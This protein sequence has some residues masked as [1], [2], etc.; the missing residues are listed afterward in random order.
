[1]SPNRPV[2]I[3]RPTRGTRSVLAVVVVLL[4][5][6]QGASTYAATVPDPG[7]IACSPRQDEAN[8]NELK[9][10]GGGNLKFVEMKILQD[11]VIVDDWQLCIREQKLQGRRTVDNIECFELGEGLFDLYLSGVRQG[12][13]VSD[14]P[15]GFSTYLVRDFN[16]NPTEAEILLVDENGRALDYLRYCSGSCSASQYW[17]VDTGC[18]VSVANVG[19]NTQVLARYPEDGT[20]DWMSNRETGGPSGP[21]QGGTN[22]A[23]AGAIDHFLITHDGTALT[24]QAETVT[25]TACTNADCSATFPGNVQ[26]TLAPNGWVGGNGQ[27]L[28]D[29][30]ADVSLRVTTPSVVTLDVAGSAPPTAGAVQC[31]NTA[32]GGNSCALTFYETGFVFDVPTLQ[33][34]A[35]SPA[36]T[37]RAVRMD[38]ATQ[39]CAPAFQGA[40]DVGF[41]AS[42]A[43]PNSGTRQPVLTHNATDFVLSSSGP[44]VVI[45]LMFDATGQAAFT[46]RYADAGQLSLNARFEGAGEEAGLVMVGSDTFVSVPERLAITIDDVNSVCASA[47]PNCSVFK[48]AGEPFP[49]KV[50]AVCADDTIVMPNFRLD[51]V[52]LSLT[53]V[54]PGLSD[55]TLGIDSFAF[56]ATDGGEHVIVDQSI[57]EVGV[58][59]LSVAAPV[60]GYFGETVAGS[61]LT[62]V[63]RFI[64]DRFNLLSAALVNRSDLGCVSSYTY[65]EENVRLSFDL[66]ALNTAGGRTQNYTSA[67]AKLALDPNPADQVNYG[68]TASSSNLTGR[69]WLMNVAGAFNAGLAQVQTTV[70]LAKT[71]LP[72]PPLSPVEFGIAPVD[73]DGVRTTGY[74]LA[75]DG[76]APTHHRLG[77]TELRF[78]RVAAENAFG[79]EFLDLAVPLSVQYYASDALG[80]AV[81]SDDHCTPLVALNLADADATDLLSIGGG[82]GPGETCV[83]DSGVPGVSGAGC[84]AVAGAAMRIKSPVDAGEHNLWLKAPDT[85]GAVDIDVQVAD[86]L[87]FDWDGDGTHD[88]A[89]PTVRATFGSY[90]GDDRIISWREMLD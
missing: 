1:M 32:T 74:D 4:C 75:L 47:E 82:T 76:G 6:V 14:G 42:Y 33:G 10:P 18:G 45:P 89:P 19:A 46:I 13:D 7:P 79:S 16:L 52:A 2:K 59:E 26:V 27:T 30:S 70:A 86:W 48:R 54:A 84:T 65:L 67:F 28:V 12:T 8:I 80:F 43:D 55:G 77:E 57:S 73:S 85:P 9:M 39:Q 68:V 21:T 62:E 90:R 88:N 23:A 44:G 60:G 35:A 71:P 24:C 53:N 64:P 5:L 3:R 81:A 31:L 38:D 63:G 78:G 37:L 56:V 61:T 49:M 22:N 72:E 36:I 66:E 25:V 20:G 40:R 17:Q 69:L 50:R 83:Q 87:R 15:Y 41:W 34:C 58:F 11:N 29:G 51:D